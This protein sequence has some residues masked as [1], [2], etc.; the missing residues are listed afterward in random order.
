MLANL[1][2]DAARL[3]AARGISALRATVEGL[4]F[5]NGFQAVVFYRLA[6]WFKRHRI[7]FFGPFF[8]RLGVLFTGAELSPAAEIGPGLRITHGV[9]LVVGGFAKIG[10]D[11]QL[12]HGVTIGSPAEARLEAMPVIGDRAFIAT[13]AT[14]IGAITIGDDVFI[15]AHALVTQDIESG[16]KVLSTPGIEIRPKS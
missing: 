12:L 6:S 5:D 4:L 9:G 13:G 3:A 14:L 1:R 15:G 11:A 10:A 16:S 2:R 7:P 8:C